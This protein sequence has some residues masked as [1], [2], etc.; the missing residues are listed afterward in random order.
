MTAFTGK[1]ATFNRYNTS[2]LNWD[3]IADIVSIGG[4]SASRDT[5]DVTTLGSPGGY[6]EFIGSLRDGGDISLNMHF[7]QDTYQQMKTDFESDTRQTYSIILPDTLNSTLQFEGLVTELPVDVPLDDVVTV[8]VTIKVSGE[9]ELSSIDVIASVETLADI[10]AANG[11][12]LANIGLPSTVEVT[13]E[14]GHTDDVTVV[15]N[16]GSP[17]YDGDTADAYT[18]TGTLQPGTGIYNPDGLTAT[19]VV[20][21]AS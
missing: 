18:F 2:T 8:D 1:G 20:N 17:A 12:Q 6:R 9:T 5:V 3:E 10:P 13:F 14:D 4:P 16:N 21:V 7:Q 19:V 15:W 11:T